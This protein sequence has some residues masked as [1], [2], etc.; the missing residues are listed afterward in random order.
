MH[1]IAGGSMKSGLKPLA[2]LRCRRVA[3]AAA[4][5]A[6]VAAAALADCDKAN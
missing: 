2:K 5:V 4:P 6:A 3:A 1:V